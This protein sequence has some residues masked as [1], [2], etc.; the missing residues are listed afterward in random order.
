MNGLS[1]RQTKRGAW[2]RGC[3]PHV[4]LLTIPCYCA[5]FLVLEWNTTVMPA[6]SRTAP[7]LVEWLFSPVGLIVLTLVLLVALT[8]PLH[9]SVSSVGMQVVSLFDPAGCLIAVA[10]LSLVGIGILIWLGM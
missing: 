4:I 9:G 5:G 6:V 7:R 8:E 2:L 10:L 3:A 1:A